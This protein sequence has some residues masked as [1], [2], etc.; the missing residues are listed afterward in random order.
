MLAGMSDASTVAG[1]F[2]RRARERGGR[3]E[4]R[5]ASVSGALPA[6]VALLV[7]RGVRRV[8]LFGSFAW[9]GA[10]EGSDVDLAVEGLP[11]DALWPAQGQ[12]LGAAPCSVDLVRIEEAPPALASR[13]R[14]KGRL[15]YG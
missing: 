15:L 6:L 2:A 7:A 9:G 8:W 5:R 11:A 10:H 13:I 14:G 1:L 12:L 4:A 3:V